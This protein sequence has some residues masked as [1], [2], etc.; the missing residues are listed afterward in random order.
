MNPNAHPA[1]GCESL[2]QCLNPDL[3]AT[4]QDGLDFFCNKK[5]V[6]SGYWN[7]PKPHPAWYNWI[8]VTADGIPDIPSATEFLYQCSPSDHVLILSTVLDTYACSPFEPEEYGQHLDEVPTHKGS[9]TIDSSPSHSDGVLLSIAGNT[10][11]PAVEVET[12][13]AL[14]QCDSSGVNGGNCRV[15][16]TAFEFSI[17]STFSSGDYDVVDVV[18]RLP[19]TF[20]AD[21]TFAACTT[22]ECLGTFEFSTTNGN[23]IALDLEWT[24]VKQGTTPPEESDGWLHLSNDGASLGSVDALYG[25]LSLDPAAEFGT[26]RLIGSGADSFGGAMASIS[27]DIIGDVS[28]L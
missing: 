16:L 13:F 4:D 1:A 28:P 18:M 19:G 22:G 15:L 23:P 14:D 10:V 26:L 9:F 5:C 6:N 11:Y 21:V 7:D 8:D 20:A 24:Q 12:N 25:E 17:L 27:F 2:P 3:Y